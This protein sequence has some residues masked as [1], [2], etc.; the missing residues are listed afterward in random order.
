MRVPLRNRR[1][2]TLLE[3]MIST[4]ILLTGI[5]GVLQGIL[6]ASQQNAMANRQTRASIIAAELLA[7]VE[8]QGRARSLATGGLFDPSTCVGYGSLPAAVQPMVGDLNP[9]PASLTAASPGLGWSAGNVSRCYI[10]FD[11]SSFTTLTNGY[12]ASDDQTYTRIV[13][14]FRNTSNPEVL[15]VGVNVAWRDG[16]QLRMV[17]RMTAIYDT[18]TN[19]T[20]LEF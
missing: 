11:A 3:G 15:F 12:T 8:A 16:G 6:I 7:A 13:G 14:V 20:N 10:D 5:V 18:T 9:A 17:K 19:Q 1:G 4:V 2:V